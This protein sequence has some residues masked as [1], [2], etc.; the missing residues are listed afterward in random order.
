MAKKK[1]KYPK[2]MLPERLIHVFTLWIDHCDEKDLEEV[3]NRLEEILDEWA[4]DDRFGTEGQL[5]P[6]GDAREVEGPHI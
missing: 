2:N 1:L 4:A 6:R 3:K 5:D